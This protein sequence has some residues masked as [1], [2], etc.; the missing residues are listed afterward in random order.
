M[1]AEEVAALIMTLLILAGVAVLWMAMKSRRVIREMEHRERLAMIERG[2]MPAPETDP[3]GFER[4][5]GLSPAPVSPAVSRMRSAGV[6]L[7]GLGL[8]MMMLLSFVAGAPG[9]GVGVGGAFAVLGAAFIVNS[10]LAARLDES[11]AHPGR[12]S[13]SAYRKPSEPPSNLAP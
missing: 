9:V 12:S 3:G 8:A 10:V 7:I 13:P 1:E 5:G 11:S 6:I 4:R 2:L